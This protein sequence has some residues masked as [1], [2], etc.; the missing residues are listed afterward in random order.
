MGPKKYDEPVGPTDS[1]VVSF[2]NVLCEIEIVWNGNISLHLG[3]IA[4][5]G[6]Y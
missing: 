3:L 6:N 2:V 4:E 5:I 1:C